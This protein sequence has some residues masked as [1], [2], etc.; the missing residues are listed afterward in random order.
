MASKF[1][2]LSKLEFLQGFSSR[3]IAGLN[4]A[5]I[6]NLEKYYTLKKALGNTVTVKVSGIFFTPTQ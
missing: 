2:I 1:G 4:P 3:I 6:H 5:V